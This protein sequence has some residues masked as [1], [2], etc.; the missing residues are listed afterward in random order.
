MKLSFK[1][2][3]QQQQNSRTISNMKTNIA[4][5]FLSN[6]SV[7]HFLFDNFFSL[8]YFF[9]FILLMLL[10]TEWIDWIC[11][12]CLF[13]CLPISHIF[14]VYLFI[15]FPWENF[16]SWFPILKSGFLPCPIGSL[17]LYLGY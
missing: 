4:F 17:L 2:V 9:F 7:Y 8:P 6:S 5:L 16:S 10:F 11:F 1:A 14:P 13:P 12:P 15:F 3:C